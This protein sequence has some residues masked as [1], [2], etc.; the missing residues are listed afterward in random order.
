M[1]GG[2]FT[3]WIDA[4]RHCLLREEV[5]NESGVRATFEFADVREL[6]PGVFIPTSVAHYNAEGTRT[7]QVVFHEIEVGKPIDDA[8]FVPEG[9]VVE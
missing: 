7:M 4:V 1:A 6:M 5:R 9:T 3:W 2:R 8:R